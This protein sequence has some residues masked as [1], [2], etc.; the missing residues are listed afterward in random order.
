MFA[1][2]LGFEVSMTPPSLSR[3]PT[4][5]ERRGCIPLSL[6]A[7]SPIDQQFV[8]TCSPDVTYYFTPDMWPIAG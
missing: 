4:P 3:R 6:G 1:K 5:V 8:K 2:E 7:E